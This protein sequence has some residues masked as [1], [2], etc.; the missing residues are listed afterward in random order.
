MNEFRVRKLP[1]SQPP[2]SQDRA[3]SPQQPVAVPL[4]QL[5]GDDSDRLL[6]QYGRTIDYLRISL[7]DQCNLRCVYCMPEDMTFRPR[8]ELMQDDE[9]LRLARLF[10]ELGF[11][12]ARL[13]GGEP[14]IR[15]NFIGL[16]RGIAQTPGLRDVSITTNGVLLKSLARP[17]ADAG[18]R[19]VNV[20]L[21]TLDPAKFKAM[22][23][24]GNLGDV[25][26]GILAAEAAGLRIKLN[27][28]VVRGFNEGADAVN[29]ARLTLEY[30]WQIRF[31]EMMPLGST[32]GFQQSHVVTEKELL[33]TISSA[34]GPAELVDGGKLDGEARLYKLP[35]AMGNLGFISAVSNPFCAGCNRVR[36]TPDGKLRLCLLREDEGDLLAP[37][38][39]GACDEEL[40]GLIEGLVHRKPWG[41]GLADQ[42]IALNRVMSEIG[43]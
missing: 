43:G 40:K 20:S 42:N 4:S 26:G 16:A 37:M 39:N 12:K 22:T 35:G 21:D 38:R 27:S 14:T 6:D 28:V 9:I 33:D 25:W 5:Q 19:R 17:L 23:R 7:T 29:L 3:F 11:R 15:E 10:A 24:W 18:V 36:L 8:A 32:A 30:P 2:H 13:T 1:S 31:L 41:H 34:L